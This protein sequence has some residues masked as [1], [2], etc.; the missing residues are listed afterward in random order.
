MKSRIFK[1]RKKEA[2]KTKKKKKLFMTLVGFEP[3]NKRS[4]HVVGTLNFIVGMYFDI[5][6]IKNLIKPVKTRF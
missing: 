4:E 3:Q 6:S 2:G 1:K 5:W